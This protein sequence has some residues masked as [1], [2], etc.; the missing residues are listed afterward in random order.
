MKLLLITN[1]SQKL[2]WRTDPWLVYFYNNQ[3]IIHFIYRAKSKVDYSKFGLHSD[4]DDEDDG[5]YISDHPI[6][7]IN[8]LKKKIER[9]MQ[10]E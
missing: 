6:K 3:Y 1:T 9:N 4:F 5:K 10:G 7:T 8:T 2:S